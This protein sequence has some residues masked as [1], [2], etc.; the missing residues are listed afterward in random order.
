MKI[1][2]HDVYD[3]DS[4]GNASAHKTHKGWLHSHL[5]I[6]SMD[7]KSTNS[8]IPKRLASHSILIVQK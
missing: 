2:L 3:E 6:V 7:Q 1:N 8:V 4:Y 5:G